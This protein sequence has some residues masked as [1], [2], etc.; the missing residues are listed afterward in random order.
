MPGKRFS[1]LIFTNKP[2][3]LDHNRQ[4]Q[5]A[6]KVACCG[7]ARSQVLRLSDKPAWLNHNCQ[8]QKAMKV[9]RCI[10]A[11]SQVLRLSD[12]PAFPARRAQQR[13]NQKSTL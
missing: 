9:A 5:K 6:M 2:A 10:M 4:P 13:M 11:R 7:M 3:W 1:S 8:P 12:K